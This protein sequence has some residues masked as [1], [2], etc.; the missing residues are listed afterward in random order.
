MNW[1]IV[2]LSLMV[3]QLRAQ[4]ALATE[5]LRFETTNQTQS[6]PLNSVSRS[7]G[8][9]KEFLKDSIDSQKLTYRARPS[10][11]EPN[12]SAADWENSVKQLLLNISGGPTQAKALSFES[13]TDDQRR[14]YG[15]DTF[16]EHAVLERSPESEAAI[17]GA[18]NNLHAAFARPDI[19]LYSAWIR[20]RSSLNNAN[21]TSSTDWLAL[22]LLD[23]E[24]KDV[25][26]LEL[27][28]N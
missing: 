3:L 21:Q 15:V 12:P 25:L 20:E 6:A 16:L 1:Q 13:L 10:K 14:R 19:Q 11:S 5:N 8:K 18:K 27:S 7:F 22:V 23:E 24:T 4:I 9:A 28:K 2:L 17:E 26:V